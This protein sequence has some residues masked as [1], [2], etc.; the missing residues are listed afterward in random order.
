M[1]RIVTAA[2]IATSLLAQPALGQ[3]ILR[4]AETEALFAEMSAPLIKAAGLNPRD[5]R[6]VLVN[7][8][9]INA[10]VAGGQVVYIH[11]GT[12]QNADT[13]NEVQGV[14]AHE[15]G[16]ITG[17]HVPLG[18]R[19]MAG[20]TGISL[21]TMVL[22]LAAIA[23]GGGEAGAGILAAGQQAALGNYLAFSRQQEASTDAAGAKYL[24]GAGVSG[25]GYLSFFGKLQRLEYRYG[26]T[27]KM[28]F[29][30]DHPVSSERVANLTDTLKA[31]PA[32]G[33]PLNVALKL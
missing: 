3:S 28:S 7:D 4:D 32:W 13:A 29:M 15:I 18:D 31:S 12:L 2:A 14:I 25:R 33:A 17:G 26:I 10:F 11:S 19:M 30:L 24:S 8:E 23:A 22:G 27:R 16:H 9:S 20:A 5:V 1:K 21:L 6:V